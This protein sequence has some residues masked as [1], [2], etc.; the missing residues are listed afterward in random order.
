M[1]SISAKKAKAAA[2]QAVIKNDQ[3]RIAQ[4]FASV[5][6]TE[7]GKAVIDHLWKRFGVD[8]RVFIADPSGAVCPLRAAVRDGERAAIKYIFAL[9]RKA[10]PDLKQPEPTEQP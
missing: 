7:D 9:A 4:A 10:K 5:L 3:D 1:E 6:M 8:E 2:K